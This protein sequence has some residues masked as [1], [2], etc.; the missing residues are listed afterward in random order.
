MTRQKTFKHRVRARMA[1]TGESYTTA[2]RI[3]IAQGVRPDVVKA[4]FA[5]RISAAKVREST[6]RDWQGWF[7]LL[8][9]RD[10]ARRSHPE[11]ARLLA[12][13]LGLESW[14]AQ[15]ITVGYEQARGLREPGQHADGWAVSASKTVAVPVERLF[16]AFVDEALRERWLSG[17]QLRLRKA[18]PHA[19]ARYDWEDGA[20]RVN[21]GFIG[22]GKAK[23]RIAIA[24]ERLP[25]ADAADAMKAWWRERVS[26]LKPLI[27]GGDLDA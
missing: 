10:G 3:L 9:K 2:R 27:E 13:E 16:E 22:L 12:D 18:T 14:W 19:S 11:L 7:A 25:D 1:K 26:A 4:R 8:D 15:T 5:P 17:A 21:V 23:S 20:T 6:G 24:H